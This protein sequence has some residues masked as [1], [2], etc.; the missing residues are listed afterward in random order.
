MRCSQKGGATCRV[1]G[2]SGAGWAARVAWLPSPRGGDAVRRL[3]PF[4]A[5]AVAPNYQGLW[6]KSPA[7]SESGWGINF[8]HQGDIIFA[9]WFTYD[10]AGKPWWLIAEL[11]EGAAG[12]FSGPVSTVAGPA[13]DA[14]PFDSKLVTESPAGTMT[15]TFSDAKNGSITYTVNGVT[16]TKA[17]APQEFG[18]LPTCAWGAEANLAAATNYTDLWW[19]PAEAGWGIN[20]THQGDIVFATWFTYDGEGKPWWLIAELHKSGA[21]VYTGGVSTVTGPPFSA[22]PFDPSQVQE[23]SAGTATLSFAHG[24]SATLAYTVAGASQSKAIERQVFRAPGT[25]CQ[26]AGGAAGTAEGR[27][28]GTTAGGKVDRHRRARGRVLLPRLLERISRP[29]SPAP[30]TGRAR[31]RTGPSRRATATTS[32]IAPCSAGLDEDRRH[33]RAARRRCS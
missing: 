7:G 33:L 1:D 26:A 28:R 12:S 3:Y 29:A 22:V 2:K 17:I 14:N 27:W 31:P 18:P 23:A 5:A 16:Q 4:T 30:S 6:W 10:L 9:T 19:N 24:N 32:S 8:A 15:A 11:H 13:Y 21:G 20:L 25:V